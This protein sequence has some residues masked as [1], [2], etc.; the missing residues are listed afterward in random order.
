[1]NDF[2]STEN[3]GVLKD[4]YSATNALKEAIRR[5]KIKL[6]DQESA[7]EDPN[8]NAAPIKDQTNG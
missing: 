4:D 3:S 7:A 2:A 5:R 1:M 6:I 8:Y